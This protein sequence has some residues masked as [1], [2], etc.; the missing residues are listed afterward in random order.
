M[1]YSKRPTVFI[2]GEKK[3]DAPAPNVLT[4]QKA[5]QYRE[6]VQRFLAEHSRKYQHNAD[7]T[8][9]PWT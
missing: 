3:P 2:V 4:P 1:D 5:Q 9:T 6:E 8:C 7:G